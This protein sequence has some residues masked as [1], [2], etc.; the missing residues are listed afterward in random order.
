MLR[1][2]DSSQSLA[3]LT[4]KSATS[5]LE[6]TRAGLSSGLVELYADGYD[7]HV[8]SSTPGVD[9]MEKLRDHEV[10]LKC[11]VLG[12]KIVNCLSKKISGEVRL[13]FSKML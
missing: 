12:R 11:F 2:L 3:S 6:K 10:K 13:V 9:C 8:G 4:E 1:N 5:L 7:P